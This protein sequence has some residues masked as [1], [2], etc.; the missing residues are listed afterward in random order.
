MD[1]PS[2][3]KCII[4]PPLIRTNEN[5][6]TI[7]VDLSDEE[8]NTIEKYINNGGNLLF[9]QESKSIANG[10][11]PNLDYIMGLYGI[12]I[13][14]GFVLDN[15]NMFQNNAGY[16]YPNINY[17]CKV[18][19]TLNDKSQICMVDAGKIDIDDEEKMKKLNVEYEVLLKAGENAYYRKNITNMSLSRA[20]D[21]TDAKDAVL[22]IYAKKSIG[23]NESQVI[24]Y[25]NSI[26]ALNSPIPVIDSIT[27]KKMAIEMIILDHNEE[28]I[29]NSIKYLSGNADIIYVQKKHYNMVPSS[30]II[31]DGI[32]LKIIFAIPLIIIFIGYFV[33]RYRKNK[34]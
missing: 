3:C 32:T 4:I 24:V 28:L 18:Y 21:D 22:G 25:S 10:E 30:N 15:T 16:I 2:D 31:T 19:T 34:K 12:H 33:W 26:F 7:A 29:A 9:L 1:I 14:D 13:P 17:N 8:K 11:T 27:N 23:N 6:E 20:E 5:G